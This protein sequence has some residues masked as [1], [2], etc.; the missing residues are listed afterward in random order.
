MTTAITTGTGRRSSLQPTELQIPTRA[1]NTQFLTSPVDKFPAFGDE[2]SDTPKTY[3]P[4]A[5]PTPPYTPNNRWVPR[6]AGFANR[7]FA[8]GSLRNPK[9][10]SR[11]SI[12]E[13]IS[14]IRTRNASVSANAQELAQA[15]RAPV[16]YKLIVRWYCRVCIGCWLTSI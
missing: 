9:Q 4:D 8:N 2:L 1:P 12:S 5:N 3:E 6:K 15:L 14:T 10:R 11:K 13:A 7:D 16:S